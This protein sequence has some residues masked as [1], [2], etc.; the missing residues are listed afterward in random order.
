M[1]LDMFAYTIV[2]VLSDS[3]AKEPSLDQE[4][5]VRPQLQNLATLAALFFKK[6]YATDMVPLFVYLLN[7]MRGDTPDYVEST[8]L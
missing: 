3:A 1:A 4:A 5:N 6:Y 8:V 7:R 2:R